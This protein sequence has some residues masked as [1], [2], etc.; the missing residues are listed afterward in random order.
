MKKN[1]ISASVVAILAVAGL[2]IAGENAT[3]PSVASKE[4]VGKG[5]TAGTPTQATFNSYA[6]GSVLATALK[7]GQFNTFVKALEITG[8]AN[9]LSGS[10]SYTIFAP[11][12]AAFAKLGLQ[13][14]EQ[15]ML[16]ANR[17]T[18]KNLLAYHIVPGNSTSSVV[19]TWSFGNTLN[20]QRFTVNATNGISVDGFKV[21]T[22]D[23]KCNNGV[24]HVIDGVMW[25]E[26]KNVL[27]VAQN[28]GKFRTFWAALEAAGL[29][30]TIQSEGP[31]TILAPSDEAFA[32][33][34]K[35]EIEKLFMPAN[36][37]QL[38][39]FLN[40]HIIPSRV[41]ADQAMKTATFTTVEG[42]KVKFTNANGTPMVNN[43]A[44][45]STDIDASNGVIHVIANVIVPSDN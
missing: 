38:V 42:G 1:L 4:L 6:E 19:G 30:S 33:L 40:A 22:P 31:F 41:F 43:A 39:E 37:A 36:K 9:E 8:L 7:N 2:S 3:N 20:G 17:E 15:I 11:T 26:T 14:L 34:P 24:I 27:E 16:P 25:P 21:V 13:K 10:N 32:K 35:G 5:T 18:L 23:I 44:I 12:D 29:T 45:T 28:A